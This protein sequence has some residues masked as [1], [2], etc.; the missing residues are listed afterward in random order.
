MTPAD[1]W[2]NNLYVFGKA[3]GK[4]P[5][6]TRPPSKEEVGTIKPQRAET[7]FQPGRSKEALPKIGL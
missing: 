1:K 4:N 5:Y 3:Y 6:H 7:I 2:H